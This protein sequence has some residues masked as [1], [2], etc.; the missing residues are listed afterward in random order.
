MRPVLRLAACLAAAAFAAYSALSLSA[1]VVSHST[2][3]P[4]PEVVAARLEAEGVEDAGGGGGDPPPAGHLQVG[5]PGIAGV[6]LCPVPPCSV[7]C[8][9]HPDSRMADARLVVVRSSGG[10]G[11]SVEGFLSFAVGADVN[12]DVGVARCERRGAAAEIRVVLRPVSDTP[13]AAEVADFVRVSLSAAGS[14]GA[15]TVPAV[16]RGVSAGPATAVDEDGESL[17]SPLQCT[18]GGAGTEVFAATPEVQ[19]RDMQNTVSFPTTG[20]LELRLSGKTGN[21]TLSCRLLDTA[22]KEA[23]LP[24]ISIEIT[25]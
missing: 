9:V 21:S 17:Y 15:V 3:S 24:L 25:P 13:V 5:V 18:V 6:G 1:P 4:A 7:S 19:L 8:S 16:L 11:G 12:G 14:G 2:P 10:G 22:G 23:E 20:D